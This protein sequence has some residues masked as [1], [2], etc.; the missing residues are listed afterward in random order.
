MSDKNKRIRVLH[1]ITNLP[2]GGAQDNT[3]LT[4][5][6]LDHMKYDVSLLCASEGRWLPRAQQIEDLNLTLVD[7]LTRKIHPLLDLIAFW[8]IYCFMKNNNIHIVHTHS[9][10][11]GFLGR[12]A[13]QMAGVPIIIHTIHGFPFHDFMNPLLKNLLI[14]MERLLSKLSDRLVT[15]ST[16]NLE[17]A[18]KLRLAERSKL[19]N[20]YSGIEFKKFDTKVDREAKKRA[21]GVSNGERV[22]GLVGRLSAQKAPLDF[23][24]AI[25]KVLKAREDVQF[26]MVGDGEL[27]DEVLELSRKLGVDSKISLL[28][29]REDVA[30]ILPILDVYVL[31]SLWEGLGRSLTEAMYMARPVVATNVE[32]VPELVKNGETGILV[33]PKDVNSIADGIVSLLS[34]EREAQ[35]LGQAAK[36]CITD[37]FSADVMVRQ[38]EKVYCEALRNKGIKTER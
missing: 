27:R 25:P 4:V 24:K 34:D 1:I 32:G 12:I 3:L 10:K 37:S 7:E 22:V 16:L 29:F 30:E 11:P 21:L 13:A 35:K 20:I 14:R 36:N 19:V 28:G 38:L 26:V 2:V 31:T 8:K 5:E 15:V 18:T 9:S 17:K 6:K 33:E 23:V